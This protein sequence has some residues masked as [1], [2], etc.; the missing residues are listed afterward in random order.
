LILRGPDFAASLI[1]FLWRSG[2]CRDKHRHAEKFSRRED[3]AGF[4][5]KKENRH[6]RRRTALSRQEIRE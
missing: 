5:Q 3:P 4:P 2:T 6:Q 1:E